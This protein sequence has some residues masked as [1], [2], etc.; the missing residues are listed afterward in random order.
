MLHPVLS[1]AA[2]VALAV[3]SLASAAH[4]QS[5]KDPW[6]AAAPSA[7]PPE[8]FAVNMLDKIPRVKNQKPPVYP[9]H[10][11]RTGIEGKVEVGFIVD[12]TGKVRNARIIFSSNSDFDVAALEA[13]ES[14]TF[15]PGLRNG[16][17]VK[18]NMSV[19]MNFY[20][21][22]NGRSSGAG[23]EGG[24][25]WQIIPPKSFPPTFPENFRF[26]EAPRPTVT[27]F[28]VYPLAL[29]REGTKGSVNVGVV[30][31]PRGRVSEVNV[32]GPAP[33]RELEMAVRAAL[34][35]W[36][37]DPAKRNGEPCFAALAFTFDFAPEGTNTVPLA[38]ATLKLVADLKK[39]PAK[40]VPVEQL[41]ALPLAIS[42][43]N[44]TY[45][46]FPRGARPVGTV[47]VEFYIDERGDARLPV[48]VNATND[49]FA[50]A[51]VQAVS[52]WHFA[53][54]LQKKKPVL[55]RARTTIE[56]NP[57]AVGQP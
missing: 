55:T 4:S 31:D 41:D 29:L 56:F 34:A 13:V 8:S 25:I 36:T 23:G 1:H 15:E 35:G 39:N 46:S 24:L 6:T 12:E 9:A 38:E 37:F 51:A 3:F 32:V 19:P 17:P 53:P 11:K 5:I 52:T 50:A 14:W 54:P 45:P 21:S 30:V 57:P 33:A 2:R 20:L 18:T 48:A 26:T 28:P 47:E 16:R 42:R 22:A 7:P 10:L 43:R 27:A 49:I 44:A 40:A